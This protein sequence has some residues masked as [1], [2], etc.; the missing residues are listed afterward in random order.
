LSKLNE[1]KL[2]LDNLGDVLLFCGEVLEILNKNQKEPA[3]IR[4]QPLSFASL[5]DDEE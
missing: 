1:V 4:S 3:E 5:S 2:K